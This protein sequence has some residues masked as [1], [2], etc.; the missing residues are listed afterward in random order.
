MYNIRCKYSIVNPFLVNPVLAVYNGESIGISHAYWTNKG[1]VV[2]IE[3]KNGKIGNALLDQIET[4]NRHE[5][6]RLR[7]LFK[8]TL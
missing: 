7:E 4:L 1:I 8:K 3:Y 6:N 5:T 2:V